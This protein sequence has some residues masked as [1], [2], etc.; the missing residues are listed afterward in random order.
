M[1]DIKITN[2]AKATKTCQI[3]PK[4][5]TS[6]AREREREEVVVLKRG[7]GG[8]VEERQLCLILMMC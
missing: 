1:P 7:K 3:G 5:I 2:T 8:G 4:C 6:N